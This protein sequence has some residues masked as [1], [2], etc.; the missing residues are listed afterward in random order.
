M[1][2][3]SLLLA[4]FAL[5]LPAHAMDNENQQDILRDE[6]SDL[7]DE[8]QKLALEN[9]KANLD[10]IEE[11]EKEDK[12]FCFFEPENKL[13]APLKRLCINRIQ[14]LEKLRSEESDD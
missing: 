5:A 13:H 14:H 4:L 8:L 9:H 3:N 12:K 6:T 2:K 11:T 10:L 7:F 1:M